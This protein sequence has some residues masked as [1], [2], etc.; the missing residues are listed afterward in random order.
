[1]TAD[2]PAIRGPVVVSGTDTEV[3]KTVV[4]A[5]IAAA[6][7]TRDLRVAV[8]KPCQTGITAGGESDVEVVTRLADPDTAVTLASYGPPLAPTVAARLTG[9]AQVRLHD[10][11]KEIRNLASHHDLVLVEGAGG[12]LVPMG[13]RN[14]TVAELAVELRAPVVVVVRAGLGTLN[15]TAL[16]LEALARRGVRGI[17]VVG[18]WPVEPDL[19]H[20]TN[21]RELPE[22]AGVVPESVGGLSAKT[23]RE[24]A[25]K[26]LTPRLHGELDISEFIAREGR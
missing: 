17:V 10:V 14:W 20:R 1:M 24:A 19:V 4:T 23:F 3:G 12:L 16:T 21:L 2:S 13:E 26:W 6:A 18:A 5:A 8:A 25:P 7:K 15:H 11:A 22:L 9:A